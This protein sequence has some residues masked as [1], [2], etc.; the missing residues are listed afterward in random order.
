TMTNLFVGPDQE[1][2]IWGSYVPSRHPANKVHSKLQHAVSAI[3]CKWP[4]HGGNVY[5]LVDGGWSLYK[6]YKVP[7]HCDF[8][9]DD[10]EGCDGSKYYYFKWHILRWHKQKT[11]SMES[12][13]V[14]RH[15]YDWF[16]SYASKNRLDP[17]TL[18]WDAFKKEYD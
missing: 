12:P 18:D 3:S 14:C 5:K 17:S 11:N 4:R 1:V 10:G 16:F 7:D 8:C 9:Y 13:V 2:K 6:E 15:C